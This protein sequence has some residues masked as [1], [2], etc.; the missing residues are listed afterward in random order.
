MRLRVGGI[1]VRNDAVLLVRHDGLGPKN[2]LWAPPGGGVAFG[3]SLPDAL[4]R[5]VREE[6]HLHTTPGDFLFGHE[7]VRP[8]LHAVELFFEMRADGEPRLGH[9]PE[10][11]ADVQIIRE[12][13]FVPFAHITAAD[14]DRYHHLF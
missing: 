4:R 11:R 1:C 8:P 5:E 10:M 14:P 12:V 6:T 9:D 7:Y 13:R 3:E 2:T